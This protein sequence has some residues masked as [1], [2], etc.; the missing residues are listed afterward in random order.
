MKPRPELQLPSCPGHASLS[1]ELSLPPTAPRSLQLSSADQALTPQ[2]SA[3]PSGQGGPVM[4]SLGGLPTLAQG[5]L[6]IQKQAGV[7]DAQ[8]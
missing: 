5:L 1:P 8:F 4:G 3:A 6:A 2:P 7:C